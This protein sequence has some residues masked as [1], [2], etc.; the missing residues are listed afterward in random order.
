MTVRDRILLAR[1]GVSF[2]CGDALEVLRGMPAESVQCCVTSPPYYGLR[3]YGMAK[4]EGGDPECPHHNLT[5]HQSQGANSQRAG[6]TNVDEQG[7][8]NYRDMCSNCGAKRVGGPTW[9]GSPDCDHEWSDAS[10]YNPNASGG[11][12]GG[13]PT[14][15]EGGLP[16]GERVADYKDRT[17]RY[18]S[19][20]LCGAQRGALGHEPTPTAYILRLVEVFREV[21]RVLHADGTLWVVIG[22]SY[23]RD[24][25]KGQHKPGD[26]G[27]RAYIYDNGR[28]GANAQVDLGAAGG[29]KP[30]DLIGIP[31]MLAFALRDDGW[32]WRSDIVWAK[33]NPM[34]ESV[35]DRC[36][37][38]HEYVFLL[39]KFERYYFDSAAISE[40]IAT[41]P[42]ENYPARAKAAKGGG[43]AYADA[44]GGDRSQSG[45]FPPR[46][47]SGNL[48]RVIDR[49]RGHLGGNIPWEGDRRNKRDVWWIPT[50]AS[51][52][53]RGQHFASFPE[54]LVE[55][56]ILAGSKPG[57]TVLD[58]FMGSGTTGAVAVR[59]GRR[60][61]GIDLKLEYAD[62]AQRRILA[63]V[64]KPVDAL[65]CRAL[66]EA[67]AD[68]CQP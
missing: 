23:A 3:D 34:P 38:S 10:W 4:W 13:A 56:M 36:T 64:C 28:G 1:A 15:L 45:G 62:I 33:P 57:D 65:G 21:R 66:A 48:K 49:E 35:A 39:T 53:G 25:K 22:D 30:K 12:Q 52:W 18:E 58:L 50:K 59:L 14:G 51:P 2:H 47:S 46:C 42:K 43:Q 7:G 26:S 41:N 19:C 32:Y 24:A 20:T 8:E 11:R 5:K 37:R 63:E 31:H 61:V 54:A 68:S 67:E 16:T 55:P 44:K 17:M 6:R 40:P 27:K 9:G 29:L 60:F